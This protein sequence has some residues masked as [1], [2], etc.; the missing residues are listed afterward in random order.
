MQGEEQMTGPSGS[1]PSLLALGSLLAPTFL[2]GEERTVYSDTVWLPPICAEN[3][4]LIL[5]P[6]HSTL[7]CQA[8][9]CWD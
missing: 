7:E 6:A 4:N 3:L 5:Y 8:P 9:Q 2:V 1:H